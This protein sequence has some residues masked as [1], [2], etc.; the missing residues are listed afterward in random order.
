MK[1]QS[2]T[3]RPG[4]VPEG[5]DGP[6]NASPPVLSLPKGGG[7]I[8]GIGEK[9]S[10]NPV[11]GT[12]AM[13]VPLAVSPGRGGFGP[14]LS[15]SYDSG[16]GNGPFGFGWSL[17]LPAI[18]RK[19]DKGLPQYQDLNESDTF[20]LSGAEDLVP[21]LTLLGTEWSRASSDRTVAGIAYRVFPYRPRIEGLFARV[22][23]WLNLATGESHWRSISRDNTST[24]YGQTPESRIADPSDPNDVYSWKI[25]ESYD[26]K[27][28]AIVYEYKAEN[29]DGVDAGLAS[30]A[31]RTGDTR[32]ANRLLKRIRYGN[33]TSHLLTPNMSADGWMFEVVFDY[34][35]HDAERPTPAENQPW[36]CRND[37]FSSYRAGFEVRTY[38]LCQRLLMFHHFP[39][40]PEIGPHYLVR[41]TDFT[42]RNAGGNPE[43]GGRGHPLASFI[44]SITQRGY[45]RRDNGDYLRRSMP[46]LEFEY[47]EAVINDSIHEVATENL[48]N[49]PAG[50]DGSTYRWADLD[51]EGI[52]GI[53]TEQAGSWYYKPN[54]GNARF[55]PLEVVAEKPSIAALLTGHQQ[56]LDVA[57]DGQLDLVDYS[58]PTPGFFERTEDKSWE[59]FTPFSSLPSIAWDDPNLRF[60]DLD[61]DGHA[62]ALI[63]EAEVFTWYRSLARDGFGPAQQVTKPLDEERGPTLVFAD[64]AQSIYLA[65][66]S[67]DGLTDLVRVRNGEVCYWPN[68]G[69]GKF[70]SKIR[71]DNAPWFD[72]PDMF[73]QKRIRLA[74]IDGS[75]TMDLIYL[76]NNGAHLYFNLSGNR[77]SEMRLVA[78]FPPTD[79]LSAVT[80]LDLLGNG[81]SCLVWSSALPGDV[82]R[83][84]RYIDLMGGQKPHLLTSVKNNLGAETAVHYAAST[85]F[86][87]TDKAAGTPWV[88]RLPFPVLV[89]ERVDTYDRISRNRFVTRY[90][91]HHGFYD[92][93]EREFR[94]FGRV[95]Q[96]DT[97]VLAALSVNRD[98]PVAD[99][100]DSQSHVPPVLTK[101]WFHNGAY[102]EERRISKQFEHEYYR[103]GDEVEGIKGLTDRQ[104][105]AMLIPDTIF[106]S[107]TR[108]QDGSVILWS[109]SSDELRESC[110]ALKGSILRQ[111]IY[112]LDGSDA[113][114]RP[115]SVSERNYTIECLQPQSRNR[116]AVFFTH[117]RETIDFHY[118][119]KLYKVSNGTI[120]DPDSVAA[121]AKIAADPRVSHAATLEVDSFG[122]VLKSVAIGYGRRFDDFDPVLTGEDKKKQ[123]Q[124]LVTYSENSFTNPVLLDDAHRTPMPSEAST[125]EL[126]HLVPEANQSFVTNLF[127]FAELQAKTAAAGDGVHDIA[128]ED[129]YALGAKRPDPY[130]RL[131]ERSRTL[132]RK[133]DLTGALP[134]GALE[135]LALPYE[136]YKLAFTPGLLTVYQRPRTNQLAENLLP[137]PVS[138]M[139]KEGG[140]VDLD[141]DGHWWVPSGQ[142]SYS[143]GLSDAAAK[144]LAYAQQHFFTTCLFRDPFQ[145][146]TAV[147]Y[148]V[149][150]LLVLDTQ[151]AVGNRVTAGERDPAGNITLRSNDYRTL[152]PAAMMDPNRNRSAVAFDILGMVVGTAVMGKPEENLGDTLA[153]FRADLDDAVIAAHLQD[154]LGNPH[155]ILQS[156]TTRLVYDL[157][158]YFHTTNDPRPRPSMVYAVARET[159]ATDL[160]AG[161]LTKIQHSFSYSDGFSREIQKKAHAEPGPLTDSGPVVTPRWVGSGWTIYNNKGKPVR[162]YEPFFTATHN[163]EFAVKV[164][165]SPILCYDPVERVVATIHPNHTFEKVVFDAWQQES[166]DVNDTVLLTDPTRDP[167]VG[168]FFRLLPSSDYE[169]TWYSPRI[170]GNLGFFEKDAAEKTKLH[171]NTPS[172]AHFDSL[173]RTFLTILDN[174]GGARFPSRVELDIE[175]I[176]RGVRDAIVQANDLQGRLVMSYDYDMLR[177]RVHQESMEAGQ[178]WVLNDVMGKA[179][180]SWDS[181]GHNFRTEYDALRRPSGSFVSGTEPDH[182]DPRTLAG[183]MLY[184]KIVYGEGLANDEGL[185]LRTRMFQHYDMAGVVTNKGLN[186]VTSQEQAFDFKGN[187]LFTSRSL[188]AD[189]KGL[190]NWS[191]PVPTPESFTSSTQYDAL[192]RPTAL[193]M[194][195]RSVVRPVYNEANLLENVSVN[196]RGA[197]TGTPFV[198]NIDYNAKGQR[199]LIEYGNNTRTTYSYDPNT[200]RLQRLITTR[201]GAPENQQIVQDLSYAYD[202]TGNI[203]HIQDNADIQNTVFFRNRRVEPSTDYVYDAIYRLVQAT[204]REQLGLG[205][206][207]P[208]LPL[209]TSYNDVP[210]VNL[211]HP[212]DG[213]A[214]GTYSEKYRYDAVGNFLSMIHRGTSPSNPGWTRSYTYDETSLLEAGKVSNRLTSTAISGRQPLNEQ[215]AYDAH[216]NMTSMPHLQVM[217]WDFKDELLMTQRQAVNNDDQEGAQH[218]GER[219]YYVYDAGGQRMRK[220]TESSAGIKIK[221]RFY[222]GSFELYRE[223]DTQGAVTLARETLHLMDDKNRVA[224]I[225]MNITGGLSGSALT[226]YQFDNHLGTTCLELDEAADLISYEEYY[227]YGSTSYQAGRIVGEVNQKRYR[228]TGKER[229]EETEFYYHG[230]RYFPPWLGRWVSCDPEGPSESA[231]SYIYVGNNPPRYRDPNGKWGEDMHFAAV[232]VA[233]RLQGASPAEAMHAAIASQAMDDYRNLAAPSLK[234][235]AVGIGLSGPGTVNDPVTEAALDKFQPKPELTSP[236]TLH[237]KPDILGFVHEDPALENRLANNA[238]ALGVTYAQSQEVARTAIVAQNLTMFGL[239]LHTVGD[240]LAHAN[241]TGFPTYGHQSMGK[242]E[243]YTDVYTLTSADETSRNPRKAL[244]TFM[245]FMELWSEMKHTPGGPVKLSQEQLLRLDDFLRRP[246]PAMKEWALESLLQSVGADDAE[247]KAFREASDPNKRRSM[248]EADVKTMDGRFGLQAAMGGWLSRPNDS[249]LVTLKTD[250]KVYTEDPSLPDIAHYQFGRIHHYAAH[251]HFQP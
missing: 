70:G 172:V 229:D 200:F 205:G 84:I 140:Y 47:S 204:G 151:D 193:T 83:T 135:S 78:Q 207:A 130:R 101:T 128:C 198:S 62:D 158:A 69:Y 234:L 17:G 5:G 240:F 243:D 163:Y 52:S 111:E 241:T 248:F 122:N 9:F 89:V 196:L 126:I 15:L 37:P 224:L 227:P 51:G 174:G 116:H 107:T 133:D 46:P 211:P 162:Q 223:Y 99:N 214:M 154:P 212:G 208:L 148:D 239:G 235:R 112:G 6:R 157:F 144:E 73:D 145:Q 68:L 147:S 18:T 169:L 191:A 225:E 197:A 110:R 153:G 53:L 76:A 138:I 22:E 38:R 173:G 195:D 236:V 105:E 25:C 102:F 81:T 41:S 247:I 125:Y 149:Y 218:Q 184:E 20:I 143:P 11:T 118:E 167:D 29:S 168:G 56:L 244:A 199:V 160:A 115:Y 159:H 228:N 222:L 181:R 202:P 43:D 226:R 77:W 233:G 170:A 94:G 54:L 165:V 87:L 34:G 74:D 124:I 155:D 245:S 106:P 45:K 221:E 30:E 182:S 71:M 42:Y 180:R 219:T 152:K 67:G 80:T 156:A 134:S 127:C 60:V 185:N 231:N 28:N 61:G 49:L 55:G 113:E 123:K 65:D 108:T 12:G 44:S 190:P 179:I 82:S 95:D 251:P 186:A 217:Q 164:G 206:G 194:P 59:P 21:L 35:E 4:P 150:D 178:R 137:D 146:T 13:T 176:Q 246:D 57:G 58:G 7:A 33:R 238:H 88:T 63:T 40:E 2:Q 132:Y 26:D 96:W 100:V 120:V 203:S 129:V 213:N 31:N 66:M 109:P 249:S 131:I 104:L 24:F 215:Y 1:E 216:G 250:V 117:P 36:L 39:Q 90:A 232:Y 48:E 27:G 121:N 201:L 19:T 187:P 230:A 10:A 93:I 97:E 242:N 64:G 220:T 79:N 141:Y 136:S 119:R 32:S 189:Y 103:E 91:Y 75:G 72:F 23:R 175:G 16:S 14:Q 209:A 98:F 161:Q 192:N 142:V 177:S 92:G 86:Y 3:K 183:E 210:R 171:A 166:W 139:N 237:R 50:L 8:Q 114:D 85:K 188:V